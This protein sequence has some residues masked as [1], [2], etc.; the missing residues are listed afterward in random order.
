MA[1]MSPKRR[2]RFNG[3]KEDIAGVLKEHATKAD[4]FEYA[5]QPT[6]SH[7]KSKLNV[8]K[9]L[10]AKE[11][12]QDLVA[13]QHN[14]AFQATKI[15]GAVEIVWKVCRESWPRK[16]KPEYQEE[17]CKNISS[18]LR[19]ACRHISSAMAR[20]A[21]GTPR[22]V[23]QLQH[24]GA[25]DGEEGDGEREEQEEKEEEEEEEQQPQQQDNPEDDH[26]ETD[27][28]E[29]AT[30]SGDAQPQSPEAKPVDKQLSGSAAPAGAKEWA[31]G[32]SQELHKAYR[33]RMNTKTKKNEYADVY[34]AE[35]RDKDTDFIRATWGS[36][37]EEIPITDITVAEFKQR[38]D[39][40]WDTKQGALRKMEIGG[41]CFKLMVQGRQDNDAVSLFMVLG[42][43]KSRKCAR[44]WRSGSQGIVSISARSWCALA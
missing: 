17:W 15:D 1:D 42:E 43:G 8:A 34:I 18:R 27:P 33:R 21:N 13:L 11:M 7:T 30:M 26:E 20:S 9:I 32:Y 41:K 4:F 39:V 35:G 40:E 37:A 38:H 36:V 19:V 6:G 3:T 44:S 29:D 2:A 14:V 24:K 10:A 16:P 28:D 5:E 12:F 23:A 31:Y 25:E 22:W